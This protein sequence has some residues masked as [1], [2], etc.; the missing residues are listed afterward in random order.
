[1]ALTLATEALLED[2]VTVV[3]TLAGAFTAADICTVP[4]IGMDTASG[5]TV[6]VMFGVMVTSSPHAATVASTAP[7]QSS[8]RKY[9]L[10]NSPS[11]FDLPGWSA[12]TGWNNPPNYSFE[13]LFRTHS[14]IQ[15][16]P[17][18]R[19]ACA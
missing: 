5:P 8:E 7:V 13:L 18:V 11:E 4:P 16:A 14:H 15:G 10:M 19:P 3:G 9:F 12:P 17:R 6:T 2:Q 1:V